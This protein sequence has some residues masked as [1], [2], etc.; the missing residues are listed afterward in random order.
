M[1]R[2]PLEAPAHPFLEIFD[3]G[4]GGERDGHV[5]YVVMFEMRERAVDMV[6]SKRAADTAFLPAGAE[7]E[8]LDYQLAAP[9]E[10]V[11]QGLLAVRPVEHVGLFDLDVRQLAPLGI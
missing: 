3:F 10:Q 11:N 7:H 4:E 8:M 9:V 6:G 5:T 2:D 1:G